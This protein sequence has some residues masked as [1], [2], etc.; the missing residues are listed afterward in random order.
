[1]RKKVLT[2]LCH[3]AQTTDIR[4]TSSS[5]LGIP[6]VN[7]KM[8]CNVVECLANQKSI[9]FL[10]T[11]VVGCQ[12]NLTLLKYRWSPSQMWTSILHSF[13]M[14]PLFGR[15]LASSHNHFPMFL[16]YW[17]LW[18][19]LST[20]KFCFNLV[21]LSHA[22]WFYSL[23]GTVN[24][25]ITSLGFGHLLITFFWLFFSTKPLSY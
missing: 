25:S 6:L 1:M 21:K 15:T 18:W 8:I 13:K 22:C 3:P 12:K 10:K 7:I 9:T 19:E 5:Q 2:L 16:S 23:L 11:M 24:N 14:T 4:K 17:C 20:T